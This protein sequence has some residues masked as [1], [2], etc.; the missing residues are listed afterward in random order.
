MPYEPDKMPKRLRSGDSTAQPTFKRPITASATEFSLY[1]MAISVYCSGGGRIAISYIPAQND[2]DT[3]ISHEVPDGW[4]SD[5]SIRAVTAV[6][7][8]TTGSISVFRLD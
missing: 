7:P 6:A 2:S 3:P 1:A 5:C 4:T 8:V